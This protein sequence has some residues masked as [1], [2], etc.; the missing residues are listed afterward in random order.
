MLKQLYALVNVETGE[1]V[2]HKYSNRKLG[3]YLFYTELSQARRAKSA[4]Y[5]SNKH[6]KVAN[7]AYGV[8][9]YKNKTKRG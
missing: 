3:N 1:V 2:Y 9:S 8:L 6:I 5:K 4:L 7:V